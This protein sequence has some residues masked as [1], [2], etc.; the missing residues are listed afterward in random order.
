MEPLANCY[1]Y[2]NR[3]D[4]EKVCS[5]YGCS[6]GLN[7]NVSIPWAQ[8]KLADEFLSYWYCCGVRY[9]QV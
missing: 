8:H 5:D 1:E 6:L 3:A 2:N 4:N 7:E 9:T